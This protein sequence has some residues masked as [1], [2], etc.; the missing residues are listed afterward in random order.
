M[1][2]AVFETSSGQSRDVAVLKELTSLSLSVS[3]EGLSGKKSTKIDEVCDGESLLWWHDTDLN[4][5][6]EL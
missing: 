4:F 1:S 3:S 2:L 5:S 6:E